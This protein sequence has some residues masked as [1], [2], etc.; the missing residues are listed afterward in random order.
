MITSRELGSTKREVK[1]TS[2]E[3]AAEHTEAQ[4]GLNAKFTEEIT[5]VSSKVDRVTEELRGRESYR[6]ECKS[7]R[8]EC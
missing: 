7:V 8:R 3:L 5:K 6:R 4:R 1:S 2:I